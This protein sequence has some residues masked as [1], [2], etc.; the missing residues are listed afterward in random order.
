MMVK[1]SGCPMCGKIPND[2]V[3]SGR[4]RC[5]H[6][7]TDIQDMLA[8]PVISSK[9]NPLRIRAVYT[10]DS[11]DGLPICPD[12]K[13]QIGEGEDHCPNCALYAC[14]MEIVGLRKRVATSRYAYLENM[15]NELQER[16][17]NHLDEGG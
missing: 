11:Q 7:G 10:I 5:S 6:C 12:C 8:A 9:S 16:F 4:G 1:I 3:L 14:E 2:F 15:L 17:D 13:V